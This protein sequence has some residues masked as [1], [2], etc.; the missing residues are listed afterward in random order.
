[1]RN[2][3]RNVGSLPEHVGLAY[4]VWAPIKEGEGKVPDEGKDEWFNKLAGVAGMPQGYEHAF[5]RWEESFSPPGVRIFE[6][7]LLSRMLIGHGNPSPT[8]VGLTLHHTWGVPYIPG[9]ALKGLV[10]HYVETCYG[11]GKGKRDE[12][13][14]P[15]RGV[16][17][18]GK[19][20]VSGPGWVH[21]ALFGAPDADEDG[22]ESGAARGLIEFHDALYV[23]NQDGFVAQDVL[24]VHHK[25]YYNSNG[26]SRPNDYDDPNPSNEER[27][28]NDYD[29]PNPVSFLTVRPGVR[30]L[31]VLTGP[32]EWLDL[33]ERFLKEALEEWGV[34]GKTSSG[35]GRIAE[36]PSQAA[37]QN[38]PRS[39]TH[40]ASPP[41]HAGNVTLD[42]IKSMVERW[43]TNEPSSKR[44][45]LW[46]VFYQ[47]L[48]QSGIGSLRGRDKE[49]AKRIVRK[50]FEGKPFS[51]KVKD[52]LN[53][54]L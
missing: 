48:E 12:E 11:P 39:E 21:K 15:Y 36:V 33:A 35:Y 18:K 30:F 19:R 42:E 6:G 4:D 49:E 32:E 22:D 2:C 47:E 45:D 5:N 24:T 28:P 7:E 9:T 1:M 37:G 54:R 20:I 51:K 53:N 23:P 27:W 52:F 31:F 25:K 34:G 50:F 43:R 3:L 13:R 26:E 10:S 29:D 44:Q 16:V 17:W 8:E 14:E 40:A 46:S 41:A 38:P